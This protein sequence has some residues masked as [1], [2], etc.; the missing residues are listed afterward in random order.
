MTKAKKRPANVARGTSKGTALAKAKKSA[1]AGELSLGNVEAMIAEY[2][3]RGDVW[4][5]LELHAKGKGAQSYVDAA[6]RGK[7]E[8]KAGLLAQNRVTATVLRIERGLGRLCAKIVAESKGGR[9]KKTGDSV[10]PVSLAD[11]GIEKHES[12]RWQ[13]LAAIPEPDFESYVA[14]TVEKGEKITTAAAIDAISDSEGYDSNEWYTP[15]DRVELVRQVLGE[16][17]LDPAS[18]AAAQKT[19]R[20]KR[21]LTEQ[22]DARTRK[23]KGRVFMNPPYEHPLVEELVRKLLDEH[24]AGRVTAS[25]TLVNNSTDSAWM[26][27]LLRRSAAACFTIGRI[28]FVREDGKAARGNRQGQIFAYIG[29]DVD[30]FARSF[31]DVGVV[32]RPFA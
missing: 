7:H 25:I 23:W 29:P 24:A 20:A 13:K 27:E 31:G 6:T 18:C 30:A 14:R 19:V 26:Q 3:K 17:D 28:A 10:S 8:R 4:G 21:F 32:L 15:A 22:Q 11:A 5:L 16:I 9:P 2:E 1:S 12:K